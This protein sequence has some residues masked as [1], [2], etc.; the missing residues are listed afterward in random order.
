MKPSSVLI[1]THEEGGEVKLPHLDWLRTS[2]PGTQIHVIDGPHSPLGKRD[3]WKNGDRPLRNWW[4]RHSTEVRGEVVAVLEWDTLVS[5][6]LPDLPDDLD[7]AGAQIIHPPDTPA[8]QLRMRD[9]RWTDA[10][11]FWWP[12][13]TRLGPGPAVGLVSFGC[14]VMRRAVLDSVADPR[15]DAAYALSIQNELRFPTVALRSGH[16][17]GT[18]DL[19]F[20]RFDD[21]VVGSA[22]G[23]YHS[24]DHPFAKSD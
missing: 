14:F 3:N 1:L 7:L 24:V 16:A 12:E 6:A 18:I 23:I 20:V 22:P 11:W 21:V 19:P 17:V 4:R 5:C 10:N 13:L 8:R 2:N 15:W 9:P